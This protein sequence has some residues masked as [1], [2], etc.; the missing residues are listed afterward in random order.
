MQQSNEQKRATMYQLKRTRVVGAVRR[1]YK[2][3]SRGRRNRTINQQLLVLSVPLSSQHVEKCQLFPDRLSM[4]SS[5]PKNAMVAEVGVAQGDFSAEIVR[6]TTPSILFLIDA[7]HMRETSPYGEAGYKTVVDRFGEG[8]T[9]GRI[10]IKRGFSHLKLAELDDNTLDWVY[11]D[12]AHDYASV[13]ADL[14]LAHAKVK[15]G[16]I[17]SG[18]DYH[19]WGSYGK[20]FGVVE[21]VNRFCVQRE[22]PLIGLSIDSD[23]NWSYAI[24]LHK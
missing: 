17:I 9:N 6:R 3:L 18:H 23:N 11:I 8:I 13:T 2:R 14:E 19:R 12:A 1:I 22:Q 21:A 24:R 7:W 20:R 5:F 16:G 10:I 4:I 15:N